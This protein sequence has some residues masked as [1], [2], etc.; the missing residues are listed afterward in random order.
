[1]KRK[2]SKQPEQQASEFLNFRRFYLLGLP[3]NNFCDDLTKRI[4]SWTDVCLTNLLTDLVEMPYFAIF[5]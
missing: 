4:K 1:M 3:L 2:G 5:P